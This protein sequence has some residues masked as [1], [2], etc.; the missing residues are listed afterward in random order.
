[1]DLHDIQRHALAQREV[2]EEVEP[3]IFVTL[4]IPTRHEITVAGLRAGVHRGYDAAS[5]SVMQRTLLEQA[6]VAWT[7]TVRLSHLLAAPDADEAVPYTPGAV[8]LLLD[9]QPAWAERLALRL[10]QGIADR[11]RSKDSAAGN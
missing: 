10:T 7:Q 4:R 9:A 11:D 5:L 3:G 1:M 6:V 8:P 2:S